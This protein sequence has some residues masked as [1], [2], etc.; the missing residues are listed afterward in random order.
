MSNKFQMRWAKVGAALGLAVGGFNFGVTIASS[1]EN[2]CE[3][4]LLTRL[5]THVVSKSDSLGAIAAK[6]QLLPATVMALNP[7]TRQGRVRPG[8]KLQIPPLDGLLHRLEN[9]DT[10]RTIASKFGLRA[11]VLFERN[12]CVQNPQ[13]VF[14][15]GAIWRQQV[16]LPDLVAAARRFESSYGTATQIIPPVFWATGGYPLPFRVVVTSNYGWRVNPVTGEYA[17]HSGIDLGAPQ[18]TP[19]LATSAGVVQFAGWAGGY[20]NLIELS[21]QGFGSRYAH[22]QAIQVAVGQRVKQ[23]QQIGLV[24]STG[25]STGPHLHFELLMPGADGWVTFDPAGYLNRLVAIKFSPLLGQDQP[26]LVAL[27][28]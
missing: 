10:Y 28:F 21:H 27:R 12:G 15:P 4:G 16:K 3:P 14:V 20:G 11:D 13:V 26:L 23:G 19:T 7:S 25:R 22:L 1:A 6:Y 24:G 9:E 18:G 2:A 17:F 8:E 5:K